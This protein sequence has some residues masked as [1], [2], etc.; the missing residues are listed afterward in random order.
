MGLI[1][2]NPEG[3][4][5]NPDPLGRGPRHPRDL[6]PHG[7]GRRGDRRAHRR[8]PHVRQVPRRRRRRPRR[9]R[10][11]GLP[12]RARRASAGRTATAPARATTRS[13]AASRAPGPTTRPRG[14][15]ASSTTSTAT[16]GSSPRARPAPS[17]GRRRTPRRQGTVPDAHDPSKRHAPMMLTTDL[18]LRIDPI[19]EPISRALPREPRP[20]RRRVRQG[21]VQAAA[22]RHGPG[23][24]AT[25]ARGCREPQLW[26][27]PVPAVD[28]DL[29]GDA[30]VAALKAQGPRLGPVGRAAGRHRVGVGG[31]LPRHRQ[32]R[33]RQR[34][35]HPPRAAEGL[36][37]QR[38]GR[39]GRRCCGASSGSSRTSTAP[40]GRHAG[41]ARR[42][43]RA[44]RRAR[45][46]RRR[47]RTPA[48]TSPC[49][50]RP[51]RTD[52][53]QEQTDVD[54]F[55]V[56]EPRADG[57]RNYLR[58]GEKLPPETLLLDR[59]NLLTLTAPEMTVLVGGMRAL[60]AN[61]GGI[62]ARRV[63]RPA[64]DA[65][66]RLL[67]ATCSTWAPSGRRRRRR[68]RLRGPRPRRPATSQWTATAVDLVF[69]SQLAAAGA[70]RGLRRRRRAASGSSATSSRRG[71]RS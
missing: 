62:A 5:G 4:N 70:R 52:A 48:T 71:T 22:P 54:S 69:G 21:L 34:R 3:P 59:A 47:R 27:D 33:R 31:Q 65:D 14:T 36:G 32:A 40:V 58:A 28:H 46:S 66:Q 29:V 57:F 68:E 56:L 41:L 6:R 8:R 15:T 23:R 12:G 42:P 61:A 1:Y 35:P 9:P 38:A 60:G 44:R 49:R 10:A 50:S 39:A 17:S 64:R 45:R 13:P 24:R 53:S 16:S 30:D 63:H 26:Q 7:D 19:Y 18:A 67:R 25:S 51:G 2:V 11:R 37:G 43:D 55:A 20:A